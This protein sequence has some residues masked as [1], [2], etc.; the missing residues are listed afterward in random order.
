MKLTR[1]HQSPCLSF[2]LELNS[3]ALGVSSVASV[4]NSVTNGVTNGGGGDADGGGPN[5]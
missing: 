4:S 3:A 1:K 2:E 5:R